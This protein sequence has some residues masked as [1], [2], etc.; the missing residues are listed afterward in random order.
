MF[1]LTD[2]EYTITIHF[3]YY[4]YSN[5]HAFDLTTRPKQSKTGYNKNEGP[6]NY[7]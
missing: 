3:V 2:L 1:K 5:Q 7:K 4:T 6:Y